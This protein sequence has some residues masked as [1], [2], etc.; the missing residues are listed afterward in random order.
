M[1]WTVLL[2]GSLWPGLTAGTGRSQES[3]FLKDGAENDSL[4]SQQEYQ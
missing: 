4:S 1:G 2:D 3:L